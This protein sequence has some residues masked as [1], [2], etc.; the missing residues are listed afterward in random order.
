MAPTS[1]SFDYPRSAPHEPWVPGG[2]EEAA[3]EAVS[4]LAGGQGEVSSDLGSGGKSEAGKGELETSGV[5]DFSPGHLLSGLAE[6]FWQE[7]LVQK[8]KEYFCSSS[9]HFL[10]P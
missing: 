9:T 7:G 5:L 1:R 8:Q 10:I 6:Q 3:R 2:T 4:D